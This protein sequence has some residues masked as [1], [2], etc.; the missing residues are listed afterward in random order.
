MRLAPSS[1]K[2][3]CNNINIWLFHLGGPAL[4]A[5]AQGRLL[6]LAIAYGTRCSPPSPS[7]RPARRP[8]A[9][10]IL[11]DL[12]Y[13]APLKVIAALLLESLAVLVVAANLPL[14]RSRAHCVLLPLHARG[15]LRLCS[16]V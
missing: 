15:C 2:H 5:P 1:S 11:P 12:V 16:A 6:R 9:P 10:D 3:M 13:V 8:I 7:L 14:A 4:A